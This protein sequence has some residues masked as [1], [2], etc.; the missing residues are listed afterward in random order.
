M[1]ALTFFFFFSM[2]KAPLCVCGCLWCGVH[3]D[4]GGELEAPLADSL[5]LSY[6]EGHLC[7]AV[8][9][10]KTVGPRQVC[11]CLS[12]WLILLCVCV[13]VC[14]CVYVWWCGCQYLSQFSLICLSYS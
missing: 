2:C 10:A 13:C 3:E 5:V 1:L 12:S 14:V 4:V 9:L 6:S 11:M 7:L 8:F